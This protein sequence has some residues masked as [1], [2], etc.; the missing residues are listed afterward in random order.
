M[1][2]VGSS[3]VVDSYENSYSN[4]VVLQN[5]RVVFFRRQREVRSLLL[6]DVLGV[7]VTRNHNENV[8]LMVHGFPKTKKVFRSEAR[9]LIKL[10]ICFDSDNGL[11]LAEE[12][13]KKI[14][15]YSRKAIQ[16]KYGWYQGEFARA[17][18]KIP[19]MFKVLMKDVVHTI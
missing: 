11:Q 10:V 9:S 8:K 17:N 14:I 15:L 19:F 1:A 12:W 4:S 18:L 5:E 6:E 16:E 2:Q 7:N 3:E 13:K